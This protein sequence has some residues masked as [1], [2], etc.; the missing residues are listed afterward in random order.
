MLI[1]KGR[2]L[3]GQELDM[4]QN[5]ILRNPEA[6]CGHGEQLLPDHTRGSVC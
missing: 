4:L 2:Y 1:G 5:P 6:R 3:A